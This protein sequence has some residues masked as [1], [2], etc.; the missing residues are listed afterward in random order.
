MSIKYMFHIFFCI[1]CTNNVLFW[2]AHFQKSYKNE[3]GSLDQIF[4]SN[5]ACLLRSS[6]CFWVLIISMDNI[7]PPEHKYYLP[8]ILHYLLDYYNGSTLFDFCYHFM[9]YILS[10]VTKIKAKSKAKSH[11]RQK[12]SRQKDSLKAVRVDN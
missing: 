10:K 12:L 5:N 1:L 11:N 4:N 8:M 9:Q 3:I 6:R 7:Q 2:L